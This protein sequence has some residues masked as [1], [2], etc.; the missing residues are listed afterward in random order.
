MKVSVYK[1]TLKSTSKLP[2]IKTSCR[3]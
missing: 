1:K 3:Y 2:Y